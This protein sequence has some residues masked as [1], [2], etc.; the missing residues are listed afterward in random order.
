MIANNLWT[1]D[2][3]HKI[4]FC[5]NDLNVNFVSTDMIG[6]KEKEMISLQM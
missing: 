4:I 3:N 5:G 6:L 1:F 2:T